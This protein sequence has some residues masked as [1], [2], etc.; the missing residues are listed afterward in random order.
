MD[1]KTIDDI[2]NVS[3]KELARIYGTD[4]EATKMPVFYDGSINLELLSDFMFKIVNEYSFLMSVLSVLK[5]EIRQARRD[6]EKDL[7]DDLVDKQSIV[8]NACEILKTQQ[9]TISRLIT[10]EQMKREEVKMY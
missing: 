9:K 8:S 1:I 3:P 5:V 6:R 10:I 4:G 7:T 2:L